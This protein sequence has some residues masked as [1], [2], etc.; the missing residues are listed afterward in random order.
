[1][2]KNID[3]KKEYKEVER[4]K[5]NAI[6]SVKKMNLFRESEKNALSVVYG[7]ADCARKHLIIY[8]KFASDSN[9]NISVDERDKK[10]NKELEIFCYNDDMKF[11]KNVGKLGDIKNAV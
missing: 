10:Y 11:L 6:N 9:N 4:V 5:K 8:E 1:M 3:L 2:T 7:S